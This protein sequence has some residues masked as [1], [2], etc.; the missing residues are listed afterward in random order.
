MR[1]VISQEHTTAMSG[2]DGGGPAAPPPKKK[3]PIG[4]ALPAELAHDLDD[5]E[6]FR[7]YV[8]F[9]PTIHIHIHTCTSHGQVD[10]RGCSS[11]H[12]LASQPTIWHASHLI[13]SHRALLY[14]V[15][16]ILH[17]KVQGGCYPETG[18]HG[19]E[20]RQLGG[21]ESTELIT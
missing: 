7:L 1:I 4:P 21:G 11:V 14:I 19:T 8:T 2:G 18:Q 3:V 16:C 17:S 15:H 13:S 9:S 20:R 6:F 5:E 10:A 12:L